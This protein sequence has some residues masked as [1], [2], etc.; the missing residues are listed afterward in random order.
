MYS[1]TAFS[2]MRWRTPGQNVPFCSFLG[3]GF[4]AALQYSESAGLDCVCGFLWFVLFCV[5]GGLRLLSP[6]GVMMARMIVRSQ[7]LGSFP[8]VS[9]LLMLGCGK[10]NFRRRRRYAAYTFFYHGWV[11]EDCV[12]DEVDLRYSVFIITLCGCGCVDIV[13]RLFQMTTS[14]RMLGCGLD[15]C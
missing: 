7:K 9:S 11:T 5:E 12:R 15:S 4:L 13:I 2:Y 10:E 1:S 8:A 3:M 6:V 14:S